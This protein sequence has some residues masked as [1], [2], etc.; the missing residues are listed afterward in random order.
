MPSFFSCSRIFFSRKEVAQIFIFHIEGP[1]PE[2]VP[3]VVHR[4]KAERVF[5]R[6]LGLAHFRW[7]ISSAGESEKL[8]WLQERSLAVLL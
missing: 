3:S 7:K 2:A 1:A 4:R 5:P 8:Y 6:R